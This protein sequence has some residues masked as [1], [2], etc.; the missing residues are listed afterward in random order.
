[1]KNTQLADRLIKTIEAD[2]VDGYHPKIGNQWGYVAGMTLKAF[3]WYAEWRETPYYHKIVK[4]HIDL[5]ITEEGKIDGY[6]INEYNLDHINKG[7]NLFNLWEESQELKYKKALELLYTQL[8]GQPRT[9]EGGFWHKKIYPFQMWL[10]GVYMSSPFLAEY[11]KVFKMEEGFDEVAKQILLIEKVTRNSSTG[12]LHH[13]WDESLEQRWCDKVT[14]KSLHVWSRAVG[15]YVM[16]IVDS[17]EHFPVDHPKRGQ[18]MGIFERL[19]HAI[20]AVQEERS[21]LWYQ[22]MDQNGREGNYLESS[23]SCMITYSILKGIR[24]G[25][26]SGIPQKA[27]ESAY[28]G[29]LNYFVT[30]DEKGVHLHQICKGAGLGGYPKYRD[31]SYPYYMSEKVVSNHLMGVAPL[32]LLSVEWEKYQTPKEWKIFS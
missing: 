6:T 7:K 27:A 12:L 5:F 15:W 13:A 23:G 4:D 9:E 2:F 10:D 32:L 11:S 31:G 16:A 18:I 25:Y 14:G 17:L 24:L 1:M 30:E 8:K 20:I 26:L 19:V 3:D 21:G 29:I 22:V 28:E